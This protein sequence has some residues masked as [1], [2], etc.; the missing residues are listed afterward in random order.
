[1]IKQEL[2]SHSKPRESKYFVDNIKAIIFERIEKRI[3]KYHTR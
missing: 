3:N 1:L 2:E